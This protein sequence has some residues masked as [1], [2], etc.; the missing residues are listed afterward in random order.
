MKTARFYIG[1]I[2]PF[3]RNSSFYIGLG[4]LGFALWGAIESLKD[5]FQYSDGDLM[6]IIFVIPGVACMFAS[7]GSPPYDLEDAINFEA[8]GREELYK[9]GKIDYVKAFNKLNQALQIYP[10]DPTRHHAYET[11]AYLHE[12]VRRYNDAI[13]DYTNA[14]ETSPEDSDN[15]IYFVYIPKSQLF[16]RRGQA[17]KLSGD[18][19]GFLNDL[20]IAADLGDEEAQKLLE[21]HCK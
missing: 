7:A 15:P 17:K 1:N 20:K 13:M 9:I 18:I 21:E 12:R 6:F 2:G 4:F 5:G 3:K 11:R 19:Q 10:R 16:R 8:E 14:I